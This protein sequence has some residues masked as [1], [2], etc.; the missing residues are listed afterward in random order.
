MDNPKGFNAAALAVIDYL[1]GD[2]STGKCFC[3]CHDDGAKPSL[4]VNNGDM[5]P[6]VI[7]CFGVGTKEH[8]LD[9]IAYLKANG[10]WPTSDALTS[11]QLS[12]Q[13]EQARSPNERRQYA[14][15]I[16]NELRK[17]KKRRDLTALLGDYLNGRAIKTVPTTALVTLPIAY[18][19]IEYSS[20][21]PGI[22]LP[23]RNKEGRFQG[24]HVIWLNADMKGKREAEPQR[25]SY[26][27]IKGNVVPLTEI[28]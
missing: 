19:G 10:A 7:H 28:D 11:E 1:N 12:T 3:P 5:R 8:D 16:W 15:D 18:E 4:Q 13:A 20:H 27:L 2:H 23:V 22:V 25:Q 24:I 9:V 21:D 14:L 6:V 26:G 17:L